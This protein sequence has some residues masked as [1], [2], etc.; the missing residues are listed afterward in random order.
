[1][2]D[3]RCGPNPVLNVSTTDIHTINIYLIYHKLT[4]HVIAEGQY[5][6]SCE[7]LRTL[8]FIYEVQ[9]SEHHPWRKTI[10]SILKS[11][12][13]DFRSINRP[14]EA[15]ILFGLLRGCD[16]NGLALFMSAV[17]ANKEKIHILGFV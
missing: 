6:F 4:F 9:P 7:L 5:A 12:L 1:M 17:T 2:S 11:F 16:F 8:R 14:K 3:T 15:E 10:D 13:M